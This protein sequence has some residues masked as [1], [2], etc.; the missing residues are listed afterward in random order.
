[1]RTDKLI[2]M[3][4]MAGIYSFLLDGYEQDYGLN[5]ILSGCIL[6]VLT[7]IT[8]YLLHKFGRNKKS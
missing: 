2:F 1:M 4:V 3:G 8:G 6:T 7:I 5:S